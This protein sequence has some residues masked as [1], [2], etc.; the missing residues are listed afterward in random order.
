MRKRALTILMVFVLTFS[1]CIPALAYTDLTNHWAKDEMED[2]AKRGYLSGYSNNT[3]KP[4]KEV[5]TCELL[6]MLSRLYTFTD[7]QSEKIKADYDAVVTKTL[8]SSLSWAKDNIGI[9]L[10]A[11]IISE[12]E[13]KQMDLT[14]EIEKQQLAIYFVRAMQLTEQAEAMKGRELSY[15][16]AKDISESSHG[17]VV[18]L[19]ELEILKGDDK[20][21]FNPRDKVT[22][23]VMA[24]AML[25][26]ID[27]LEKN[28]ITLEVQEY[29][30]LSLEK[31]I[32]VS[33]S[34]DCVELRGFDG[35]IREYKIP[36]GAKVTVDGDSKNLTSSYE[37]CYAEIYLNKSTVSE[38][39]IEKGTSVKWKQGIITTLKASSS[40]LY[41]KDP[42]TEKTTSYPVPSSAV[43][44]E[45]DEKISLSGITRSNFLTIR[46]KKDSI[47]NIYSA[48]M[49][50]DITGVI[51]DI[52]YGEIVSMKI[53][54]ESGTQYCFSFN[55]LD[56]PTIKR[57][58]TTITID[59]LKIDNEV[60]MI[61]KNGVITHITAKGEEDT[62]TGTVTS[63]TTSVSGT[64]WTLRL[65]SGTERSLTLDDGVAVYNGS[66]SIL[67]SDIRVGDQVKVVI[68]GDVVT[69]VYLQ[70]ATT[71]AN[72]I[73]GRI[74]ATDNKIITMITAADKLIYVDT[75]SATMVSSST[76]KTVYFS[77]LE[78]ST[79]II[80]YGT[81]KN[82]T[83]FAA[84]V[85]IL[86]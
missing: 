78:N 44:M 59:R 71:S 39:K 67:L 79:D 21:N 10:A 64:V 26:S 6:V 23:A 52:N 60:H 34:S 62:L 14:A 35:L 50:D 9:C 48:A 49:P 18:K 61:Y 20:N 22:R 19:A 12:F 66:T 63:M 17:S 57:G 25:R 76:G 65:S 11:G 45:K 68:Y 70:A 41:I 16:D 32:L 75:S 42:L 84:T 58:D 80:A 51:S 28:E 43:V 13:L 74:L 86:P 85:I 4:D 46:S 81:Y 82:A 37:D 54:D 2:L 30:G 27:Y 83:E 1:I 47:T 36:A 72:T 69:D 33:S 56:L 7:I 40:K 8:P 55:I 31:G 53:K 38:V 73:S 77:K 5:T 3:M 29:N 24:V 15:G